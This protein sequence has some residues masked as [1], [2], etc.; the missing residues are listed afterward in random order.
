MDDDEGGGGGDDDDDEENEYLVVR[1]CQC[2][3]TSGAETV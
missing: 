1:F 3:V 2:I